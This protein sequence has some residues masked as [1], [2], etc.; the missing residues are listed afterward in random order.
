MPKLF[1]RLRPG[2]RGVI[3]GVLVSVAMAAA[4]A[5]AP[6]ASAAPLNLPVFSCDWTRFDL[7]NGWQSEQGAY[8]TGNPA[9]CV[10]G[11]G[12]VYL[13]GSLAQPTADSNEFAVLPP[14]ARPYDN[15]YLNLSTEGGVHASLHISP[16]GTMSLWGA[17]AAGLTS[18]AGLSFQYT[19]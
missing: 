2:G 13:S 3:A 12:M 9:Y 17:D 1:N 10:T 4:A 16:D 6:A 7:M 5:A 15:L 14:P 19:S 18:L 8:G 11:E